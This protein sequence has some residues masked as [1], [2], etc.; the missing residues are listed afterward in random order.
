MSIEHNWFLRALRFIT[1]DEVKTPLA[2]LYKVV[3]YLIAAL[4]IVLYAPIADDMKLRVLAW[5][6][7]V[8]LGL[9]VVVLLF[10]WFRPKHLVYGEM[11]H[12]AEYKFEYGTET[13]IT[14]REELDR[15]PNE[16][17]PQQRRLR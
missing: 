15:L 14:T 3:P 7:A 10:A 17:D 1:K 5:T 2:F 4:I 6:F 11:G 9:S 12:R 8:L 13:R 16:P